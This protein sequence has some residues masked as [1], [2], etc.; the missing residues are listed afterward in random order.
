MSESFEIIDPVEKFR[1]A[2][3][4]ANSADIETARQGG[5]D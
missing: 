3:E 4:E 1:E 2:W 5:P